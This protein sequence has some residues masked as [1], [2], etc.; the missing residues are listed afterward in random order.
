MTEG[1]FVWQPG[2]GIDTAAL[3][4]LRSHFK[5][6]AQPMGEAWF[7]GEE[8]ILFH[9][10]MQDV[11]SLTAWQLQQ[12]LQEIASGTSA[13]GSRVEW[14][15][16]YHY[17]LGQVLPRC[18]EHFVSSLLELLATSFFALYPNGIHRSPYPQFRSDVLGTLG[19]CLMAPECWDS[20]A[21]VVGTILHRS[22]DNP[23]RVWCWWDASGD[24]SASMYLC[25]KYLPPPLVE[26]W[27]A[28]V[29]AIQ[30]PHWRAQLIVWLVGS[31]EMLTGQLRWP[32][33]WAVDA[34]PSVNWDWS[35]CL[36]PYVASSD[37]S[38]APA[39]EFFL[40]TAARETVLAAVRRHF[41]DDVYLGWLESIAS[42]PSVETEL[43]TIPST[44]E[45]MYIRRN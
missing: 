26:N 23:N 20:E 25:L 5:R 40:P 13:F 11:S 22:N 41:T 8:R 19:Q 21:I 28:S 18:H 16:W 39:V 34:Y 35:H 37:D 43:A 42:V 3:A 7:M 38:G 17:L 36:R 27:F 2:V 4:R 30:S 9:E 45:G 24:F 32:S 44:F 29:L 14:Y 12:P 31:H 33:E 15:E 1:N 6:P 10:L